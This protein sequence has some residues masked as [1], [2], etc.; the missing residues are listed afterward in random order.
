[1]FTERNYLDQT[2]N[3]VVAEEA[4]FEGI[5]FE[6]CSFAHCRFRA[7]AFRSCTF[8]NCAFE[9]CDLSM[10]RV[11]GSRFT[12][13]RFGEC[14]LIGIDWTNAS[15]LTALATSMEFRR[16]NLDY[17]F[18]GKLDLRGIQIIECEAR[19]VDFTETDL[20]RASFAGS[21]LAGAKFA[22][23]DLR[24]A[25]FVGAKHYALDPTKNK[26]QKARFALPEVV[27]LLAPFDVVVELG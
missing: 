22:R 2:F 9:V 21:D 24:A 11:T 6:Q 10:L 15:A 8:V 17:S 4:E 7:A 14:K 1:M 26:V 3:E 20:R 25:N 12:N 5:E 27:G 13:A 23:T 18:F 16:C 19:E